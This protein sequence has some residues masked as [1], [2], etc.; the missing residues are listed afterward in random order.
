MANVVSK[1]AAVLSLDNKQ[2]TKG[3]KQSE[4]QTETFGKSMG[5]L[6][7]IIAAAFATRELLAFGVKLA[8]LSVDVVNVD[9]AFSK[10]GITIESL[11]QATGGMISD[12]ELEKMAVKA[13]NLGLDVSQLATFFKFATIRAAETG[14]SVDYLVNSIVTGIG[15]KSVMIMDNLG[16][17]SI[18]LQEE[19]KKVGSFS[20]AAANIINEELGKSTTT[21]DQATKGTEQLATAWSNFMAEIATSGIGDALDEMAKK[22]ALVMKALSPPPIAG[23]YNAD[24]IQTSLD[25]T[26]LLIEGT[27]KALDATSKYNTEQISL[28]NAQLDYHT[29]IKD[30]LESQLV[31]AK[32]IAAVPPAATAPTTM[33]GST[34]TGMTSLGAGFGADPTQMANLETAT[35]LLRDHMAASKDLTDAQ[36]QLAGAT[37]LYDGSLVK[38]SNDLEPIPS[39]L[40]NVALAAMGVA[41]AVDGMANA[42]NGMMFGDDIVASFGDFLISLASLMVEFGVLLTAFGVAQEVFEKGSAY[43][44]IAAGIAMVG[45]AVKIGAS[46]AKIGKAGSGGTAGGAYSGGGGASGSGTYDYN[47]EMVFVIRGDD[48]VTTYNKNAI[49]NNFNYGV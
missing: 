28:L 44:K 26:N 7:G 43:A 46:V 49:K 15:R 12:F 25:A 8:D 35:Q 1:L 4:K 14:E 47:R 34:V 20:L 38:M 45:I 36:Y 33:G 11:R 37:E 31:I 27:E 6:G 5:K 24:E 19:V 3:L 9:R 42:L 39:Q 48:L 13:K 10:L 29:Q 40:E 22:A 21:V 16:I 18:A 23:E 41:Y 17:S 32:E 2:F 30:R